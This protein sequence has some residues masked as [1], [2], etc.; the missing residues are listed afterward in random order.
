MYT[1]VYICICIY[2]YMYIRI[3][4]YIYIYSYICAHMC[5]GLDEEARVS[6]AMLAARTIT[7][8][9][10]SFFRIAHVPS[11]PGVYRQNSM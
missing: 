11:Q 5:R 9:V 10:R 6:A 4:M 7:N 3:Y 1:Y 8:G 2:I